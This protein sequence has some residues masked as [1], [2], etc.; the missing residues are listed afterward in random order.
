MNAA[1]EVLVN[2]FLNREIGWADIS[3]KLSLLMSGHKSEK[4]LNLDTIIAV[5]E[6]ARLEASRI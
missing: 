2:R 4:K 3:S 6:C 1:N 5:D